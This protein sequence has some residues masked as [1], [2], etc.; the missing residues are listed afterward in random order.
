MF[1]MEQIDLDGFNHID[2]ELTE[3]EVN[4]LFLRGKNE[5]DESSQNE[6]KH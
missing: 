3:N 4:E 1:Y 2:L 6:I 5:N